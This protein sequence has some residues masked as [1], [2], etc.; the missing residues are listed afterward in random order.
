MA[1]FPASVGFLDSGMVFANV[2]KD[3]LAGQGNVSSSAF[4]NAASR[5]GWGTGT[6]GYAAYIRG[7]YDHMM[8]SCVKAGG[9]VSGA[10]A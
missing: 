7:I 6:A 3:A 4:F 2:M 8:S 9:G 10:N 5:N 1:A